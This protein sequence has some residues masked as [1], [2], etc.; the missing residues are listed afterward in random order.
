MLGTESW[1]KELGGD[2]I[3]IDLNLSEWKL[4]GGVVRLFGGGGWM[5]F[6]R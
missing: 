1:D 3:D 6:Y 5:W 2:S 4:G